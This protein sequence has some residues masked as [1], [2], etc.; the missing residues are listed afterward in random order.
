[1]QERSAVAGLINK[2]VVIVVVS[3]NNSSNKNNRYSNNNSTI[4]RVLLVK[5][6]RMPENIACVQQALCS[7]PGDI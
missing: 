5:E 1:V 4:V 2:C 3:S 7:V 6:D